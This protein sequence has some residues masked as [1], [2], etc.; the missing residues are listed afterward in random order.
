MVAVVVSAV[1]RKKLM[2]RLAQALVRDAYDEALTL[3]EAVIYDV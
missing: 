1:V 2:P 3:Y